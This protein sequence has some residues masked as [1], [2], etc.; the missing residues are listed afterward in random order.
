MVGASGSQGQPSSLTRPP[1]LATAAARVAAT[2][3]SGMGVWNV[4]CS[5]CTPR[6]R[7][8]GVPAP[9]MSA[10]Q[11]LKKAAR[12]AISGSAAAPRSTVSPLASTAAISSV[13]VAPTLGRRRL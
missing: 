9:W 2:M 12:S 7:T 5:P 4:P 11:A 8:S 10:P 6:M 3:R 13:S 1:A